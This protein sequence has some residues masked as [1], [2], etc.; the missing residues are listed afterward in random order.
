MNNN[1]KNALIGAVLSLGIAASLSMRSYYS[2]RIR[3]LEMETQ[4]L[5]KQM[6]DGVIARANAEEAAQALARQLE[7][8]TTEL[9]KL[10]R[11]VTESKELQSRV[12]RLEAELRN[13]EVIRERN[14]EGTPDNTAAASNNQPVMIPATSWKDVGGNSAQDAVQTFFWSFRTRSADRL[15]EFV[16]PADRELLVKEG[17]IVASELAKVT[18]YSLLDSV[19]ISPEQQMLRL[20]L[21]EESGE[22]KTEEFHF[23]NIGGQW[24]FS[25]SAK[26]AHL[27]SV[28]NSKP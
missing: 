3:R 17:E 1:F 4:S 11:Q 9:V 20:R 19:Q 8:Q 26:M 23:V 15:V 18:G 13:V 22:A 16:D 28:E 21:D 10:R 6:S 5:A 24:H 14:Q 7:G 27:K 25:E 12:I 2:Q